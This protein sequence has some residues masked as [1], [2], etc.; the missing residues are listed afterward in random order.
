MVRASFRLTLTNSHQGVWLDIFGKIVHCV[1]H[2][3][4]ECHCS[5]SSDA[6]ASAVQQALNDN[7]L[8]IK[9]LS[10]LRDSYRSKTS[11][12]SRTARDTRMRVWLTLGLELGFS[13]YTEGG[14]CWKEC[15]RHGRIDEETE[16]MLL[17]CS[18][19]QTARYCSKECQTK[20]WKDGHK[21]VCNLMKLS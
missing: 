19:C 8:W 16:W 14:C 18:G 21:A 15:E 10:Q 7:Q 17:R 20:G 13:E 2:N 3:D 9:T 1:H 6:Y 11:T 5:Q 4:S 12:S